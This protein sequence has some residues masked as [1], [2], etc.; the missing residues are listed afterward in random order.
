M[1]R[2]NA[3][4]I[5]GPPSGR[6][7]LNTD[8]PQ[9]RGLVAWFPTVGQHGPAMLRD[10]TGNGFDLVP[11][12]GPALIGDSQLARVAKMIHGSE[13]AWTTS[14]LP[15]A[16]PP[17]ALSCWYRQDS[18]TYQGPAFG[19]TTSFSSGVT[20]GS[21]FYLE[22]YGDPGFP[23][24]IAAQRN[25]ATRVGAFSL[26]LTRG[27]WYH[28]VGVFH[29]TSLRKIYVNG[30]FVDQDIGTTSAMPSLTTLRIGATSL[31]EIGDSIADA[32]VYSGILSP[33]D[34]WQLYSRP[35]DLYRPAKRRQVPI[36]AFPVS[37]GGGGSLFR[38]RRT[39]SP[40]GARSGA[41]Q[42]G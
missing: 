5:P 12:N 25:T 37:S 20:S 11:T 10:M 35:W 9:A 32:R 22:S 8:S 40:H 14:R 16:V 31:S 21:G 13:Q 26:P 7:T 39:A 38:F 42:T 15:L 24:I 30:V 17:L 41:R 34:V 1:P 19:I 23:Q 3:N 18:G 4:L 2:R 27:I 33:G 6:F 36:P 28:V 29:S